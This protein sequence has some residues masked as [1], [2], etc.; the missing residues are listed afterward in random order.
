[1]RVAWGIL[2]T[3]AINRLVLDGARKSDRVDV[4]AVAS[5][6]RARAESFAREHGIERAHGG[7]EA[8]LEDAAVD[9]VYIPLPNSLHV[10]WSIRA[11]EAGKHV[12]CE[13]PFG[14]HA[15]EVERAFNAAERA[16]RMLAEAFMYRHHPQ[17]KHARQL[18]DEGTIGR[19]RSLRAIH[20]FDIAKR[21]TGDDV[22]L[23]AELDGGTLMD[24][25]CYCVNYMRL[26][27]GEPHRVFGEQVVGET[28]VDMDFHAAMSFSADVVGQFVASFALPARQEL[29]AIGTEG[30]LRLEAPWRLDLG[31]AFTL[32]REGELVPIEVEESDSY[33]LELEDLSDAIE[34]RGT[35]L[36]GRD[37]AVGNARAIEALYRSAEEGSPVDL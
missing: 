4:V 16:G 28:D 22:R 31:G 2:S 24:V 11:L 13:K 29:E 32:R 27:A 5:R 1:V 35:P 20:S 17:T 14:R 37:D 7:Y 18:V 12:L 33:Q 36:L 3:A 25:G 15:D 9:A 10:D 6:D 26:L 23:S 30:S 19:L 34:G 21:S 8:L